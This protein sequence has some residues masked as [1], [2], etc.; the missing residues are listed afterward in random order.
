MSGEELDSPGGIL[1]ST[2]KFYYQSLDDPDCTVLSLTDDNK[3]TIRTHHK[4]FLD[5]WRTCTENI[6]LNM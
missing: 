3:L 1:M 4:D 2:I 6:N 5:V